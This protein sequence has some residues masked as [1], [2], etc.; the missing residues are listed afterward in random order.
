MTE[1]DNTNRGVLF[2]EEDKKNERG[3]D[4]TGTVNVNGEDFRLAGWIKTSQR[5]GQ[6]F[7][8]LAVSEPQNGGAAPTPSAGVAV[9]DVPF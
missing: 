1:Y 5:S 7:L 2:R 6:K 9:D 8:S 4:Y 3:P